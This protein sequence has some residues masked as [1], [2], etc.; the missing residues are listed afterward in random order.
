MEVVGFMVDL[1]G[2][3]MEWFGLAWLGLEL[4]RRDAVLIYILGG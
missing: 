4:W 2:G 1:E 3:E